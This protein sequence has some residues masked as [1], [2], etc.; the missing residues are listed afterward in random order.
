MQSIERKTDSLG[1]VVIPRH[2]R[3]EYGILEEGSDVEL[4]PLPEGI[5]IRKMNLPEKTSCKDETCI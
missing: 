1:R 3:A 2:L 5:L 4:V